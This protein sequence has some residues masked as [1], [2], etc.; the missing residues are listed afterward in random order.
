MFCIQMCILLFSGSD[1]I[2]D[3]MIFKVV[4]MILKLSKKDNDNF[5]MII[6]IFKIIID[7]FGNQGEQENEDR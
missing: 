4:T 5:K 2:H 1:P 7:I 6:D 3:Q